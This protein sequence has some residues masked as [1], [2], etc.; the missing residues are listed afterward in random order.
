VDFSNTLYEDLAE[1]L[2]RTTSE[3]LERE[4]CVAILALPM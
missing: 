3:H 1:V 4:A 2:S